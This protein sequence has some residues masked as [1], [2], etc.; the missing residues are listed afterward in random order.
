[1]RW[2]KPSMTTVSPSRTKRE[3]ASRIGMT[4]DDT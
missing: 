4:L 2:V 3:T 1:M